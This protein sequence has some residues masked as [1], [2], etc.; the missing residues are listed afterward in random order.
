[1]RIIIF[2]CVFVF[3]FLGVSKAQNASLNMDLL[4][5]WSD[6][7]LPF[8]SGIIYNDIWGYTDEDDNE[9]A[10]MGS[11]QKVHFIDITTQGNYTEVAAISGGATSLWRDIKTYGHYAYSVADQGNEGLMIFDLSN[12]PNSVTKV[13]QSN[14]YFNRAHNVFVDTL[15]G[16]LYVLGASGGSGHITILDIATD[17]ENPILL[18]SPW[19]NGGY[20]HDAYVRD[21]IVYCSHGNNGLYVYD[22]T[23][24]VNPVEL[25]NLTGYINSG[26]NHSSW[27]SEDGETLVFCDETHGRKVKAIDATDLT[28]LSVS[29]NN[30]FYSNLEDADPIT[31]IA[32]NP[33]IKGDYAYI[34]Y[35]HDGIQVFDISDRNNVFRVAYYDT[36]PDNSGYGGYAGNWGIY[37]LFDSGKIIVSDDIYGLFVL[38]FSGPLP[39]GLKTFTATQQDDDAVRLDWATTQEQN[40][41]SFEIQRSLDGEEFSPIGIVGA[42][43]FS[44]TLRKYSF[45]DMDPR[46]GINYYRL[47]QTDFDGKYQFSEI[48]SVEF[49]GQSFISVFPTLL[50]SGETIKV[51]IDG[52]LTGKDW[53]VDLY[54]IQG[55]LIRAQDIGVGNPKVIVNTDGLSPG[56][57]LVAVEN[58]DRRALTQKIIISE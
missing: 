15:H 52:V 54:D 34:S 39:V 48:R 11:A 37:P 14:T 55:R 31:S 35:Y 21:H 41:Q 43:G 42:A 9:F 18:G 28:N 47:K 16:R 56:S 6:P 46:E 26:Y 24:P 30:L 58:R 29:Q 8:H 49:S 45:I 36:Y 4:G 2:T 51:E 53:H 33:V 12:L 38:E 13:Y 27:L 10:I 44:E 40:S 1:M 19:L 5:R 57:Y 32:H 17:P 3:S 50:P 20:I 25:G 22:M 7:D 23:D